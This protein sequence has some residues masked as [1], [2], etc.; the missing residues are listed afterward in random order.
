MLYVTG[1]LKK[2]I[3]D[4]CFTSQC[5]LC[6]TDIE[7]RTERI[8]TVSL[9]DDCFNEFSNSIFI[10]STINDHLKICTT[11]G[12]PTQAQLLFSGKCMLCQLTHP[13]FRSLRSI[14]YYN[15][16]TAKLIHGFKYNGK[17]SH[18][19]QI[20]KLLLLGINSRLY[21][22]TGWDLIVPIPSTPRTSRAR[23]FSHTALIARQLAK[24]LGIATNPFALNSKGQR[25]S[26]VGLKT[27]QRHKNIQNSFFAGQIAVNNKEILLVDDVITTGSTVEAATKALLKAG[28]KSVDVITLLRSSLYN[29]NR[30]ELFLEDIN[31]T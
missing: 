10:T 18:S 14:T 27:T 26:Q 7:A 24:F 4:L 13:S 1:F 6:G 23:G 21:S 28:A 19:S 5:F 31:L 29:T 20:A 15:E 2:A 25:K 9:C 11:C 22:S 8:S 16:F 17:F 12:E 3:L 30:I